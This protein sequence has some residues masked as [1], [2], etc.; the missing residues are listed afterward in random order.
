MITPVAESVYDAR[1]EYDSARRMYA[2]VMAN[3]PSLEMELLYA[4]RVD[5]ARS[6]YN[7]AVQAYALA[8]GGSAVVI[9]GAVF[10]CSPGFILPTP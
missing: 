2:A 3:N 1:N 7:D 9:M 8:I 6:G 4:Q 10:V 5:F